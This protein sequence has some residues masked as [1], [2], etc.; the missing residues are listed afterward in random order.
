MTEYR[1]VITIRE[2]GKI[3]SVSWDKYVG[4]IESDVLDKWNARKS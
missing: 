2:I 1:Y 3:K 4:D